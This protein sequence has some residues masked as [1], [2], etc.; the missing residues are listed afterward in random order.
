MKKR[1]NLGDLERGRDLSRILAFTDGVFAIAATLLVLQIEVPADVSSSSALWQGVA[2]QSGDLLAYILSFLVIAFFWMSHHRF[3]RQVREF[4]RGLML[5]NVVYLLWLVLI[6]FTSQLIGEYGS[7]PAGI[8]LYSLNMSL[9]TLTMALMVWHCRSRGLLR[10]GFE[11][12]IDLTVKS[13]L[14]T[15][16]YFLIAIPLSLLVGGWALLSWIG[17]RYDPYQRKRDRLERQV[18]AESAPGT[19]G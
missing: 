4:D 2:D 13:G 3:M 18:L 7:Y 16:A 17:L 11:W 1:R 12:D 5:L 15:A 10:E 6:P 14:F 19:D 9:V 8:A